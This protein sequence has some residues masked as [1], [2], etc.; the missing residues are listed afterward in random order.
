MDRLTKRIEE[1]RQ[2]NIIVSQSD[3]PKTQKQLAP[4]KWLR[5]ISYF[6]IISLSWCFDGFV[7]FQ[8]EVV[9]SLVDSFYCL[10]VSMVDLG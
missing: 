7:A 10:I 3:N 6:F 8:A 9:Q 5:Y 4:P 1:M 2:P